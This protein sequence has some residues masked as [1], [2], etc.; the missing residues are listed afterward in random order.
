M[1]LCTDMMTK[2]P[3]WFAKNRS[4]MQRLCL[5]YSNPSVWNRNSLIL[6][7]INIVSAWNTDRAK[8]ETVLN[9]F[10]KYEGDK[11]LNSNDE[12]ISTCRHTRKHLLG[13]IK[14]QEK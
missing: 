7:D 1:M 9:R 3:D 11:R 6:K 12:L 14:T 5:D 2:H 13:R 8:A 4:T 10:M